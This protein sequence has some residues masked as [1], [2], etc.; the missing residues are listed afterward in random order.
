MDPT[1]PAYNTDWTIST[2]SNAHIAAHRDWFT[3]FTPFETAIDSGHI[4]NSIVPIHGI[5]DIQLPLELSTNLQPFSDDDTLITQNLILRN[6]LF[7]PGA[8]TNIIAFS[9]LARHHRCRLEKGVDVSEI[10]DMGTRA[11]V[12]VVDNHVLYHLRLRGQ[13]LR[14]SCLD[15]RAPYSIRAMW[16]DEE[17]L[18]WQRFQAVGHTSPVPTATSGEEK[19]NV[20]EPSSPQQQQ[21]QRASSGSVAPLPLSEEE[22]RYLKLHWKT[23]FNFF[24]EHG[25]RL[26]EAEDRAEGRQVLKCLM[27]RDRE[28]ELALAR[29][30]SAY[31]DGANFMKKGRKDS[32]ISRDSKLSRESKTSSESKATKDSDT[33]GK[34]GVERADEKG[35]SDKENEGREMKREYRER[36]AIEATS[37]LG[38]LELDPSKW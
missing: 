10:V 32:K 22:K 7:A 2:A 9:L 33:L 13:P 3:T 30:N 38:L 19:V 24:R 26:M 21:S 28:R 5:G 20:K 35:S 31:G 29:K 17:R 14:R 12:A 11:R 36:K 6:V 23:E 8:P 15:P 16:P 34:N 1:N 4:A 27:D 18:R 37:G 25:L